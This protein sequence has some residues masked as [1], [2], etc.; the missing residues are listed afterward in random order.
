MTLM[1]EPRWVRVVLLVVLLLGN[2]PCQ[3]GR[4]GQLKIADLFEANPPAP[5]KLRGFGRTIRNDSQKQLDDL[6][7]ECKKKNCIDCG[8]CPKADPWNS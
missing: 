4:T 6:M 5:G 2:L 8:E 7:K 3:Q 1:L